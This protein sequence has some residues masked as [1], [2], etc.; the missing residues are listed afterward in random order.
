M[1]NLGLRYDYYPGFGYKSTDEA[2]PAEVNNL[3][4]PTDLPQDGFRRAAP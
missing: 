3:S 2:D 1:L 4:N